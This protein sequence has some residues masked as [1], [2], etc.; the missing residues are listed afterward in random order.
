MLLNGAATA[1]PGASD[2]M[3]GLA[4]ASCGTVTTSSVGRFPVA[5]TATDNAGNVADASTTYLVAYRFPGFLSP[6][7]QAT[8][9][10]GST[11]RVKFQLANASGTPIADSMAQG[12]SMPHVG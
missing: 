4:S 10:V 6:L 7:P 9:K 2:A 8:Y 12:L 5:C 3:S 1:N 11:I